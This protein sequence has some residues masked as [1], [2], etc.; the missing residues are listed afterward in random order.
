MQRSSAVLL[1]AGATGLF[2]TLGVLV[3]AVRSDSSEPK[4]EGN[5]SERESA[6]PSA[7]VVSRTPDL[8]GHPAWRTASPAHGD[9]S[10]AETTTPI[11]G[12]PALDESGKMKNLQFGG[13]QL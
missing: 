4:R 6:A 7:P 3:R 8:P 9:D 13:K 11:G 5:I 12:G 2:V 1:V 10:A